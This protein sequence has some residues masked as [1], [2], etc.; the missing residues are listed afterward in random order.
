MYSTFILLGCLGGF[1][2]DVIRFIKLGND[3]KY[4]MP[5]YLGKGF[6]WIVLALQVGLGALMV[7]LFNVHDNLQAV[8]YGYAAPQIFTSV[9]SGIASR[10]GVGQ[11]GGHGGTDKDL[12]D[13]QNKPKPSSKVTA[14]QF[15]SFY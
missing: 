14:H 15:T 8:V 10:A 7:Y 2:P 9:A 6:F 4:T 3:G 5:D 12:S 13:D 11:Q 1:L